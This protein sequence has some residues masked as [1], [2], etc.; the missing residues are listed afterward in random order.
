MKQTDFSM[1]LS[2]FL[3]EYLPSRKNASSN[4]IHSYCDTFRLFL[5]YCQ[6]EMN[7]KI[8]KLSFHDINVTL[9]EG[10]LD[11]LTNE[12][13]CALSTYN[14]RLAAIKSFLRYAQL[15]NPAHLSNIQR[16]MDI[17]IQK[18]A[19]TP[20]NYLSVETVSNIL[21]Q[22]TQTTSAGRRDVALLTLLY[23]LGARVQELV[24]LSIKDIRLDNPSKVRLYGKGRKS[25]EVPLMKQTQLI[26]QTYLDDQKGLRKLDSDSPLFVNRVG[27]RLTRAGV[28]YILKKYYEQAKLET[29]SIPESISPHV[30]RHSKA[31]HL[32]QAG[33]NIFYIKD[34]LGHA[35]VSTTEIYAHADIEMKR[36]AL[37]S[38]DNSQI[39]A[40]TPA[41]AKDEDLLSWLKNYGKPA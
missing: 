7:L 5:T 20:I 35:N 30:M 11:W 28:T 8:E 32:L 31:M 40:S 24:S 26:M 18:V 1:T 15:E 12:R 14:Q 29:P 38:L 2:R 13:H 4:T 37:N 3:S 39:P 22:P 16:A 21:A 33:I 17:P 10:F 23:D 25:R 36:T 19:S 41:W 9:I 34:I 27:K 6:Q